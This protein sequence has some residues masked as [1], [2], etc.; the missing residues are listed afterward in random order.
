M[1]LVEFGIIFLKAKS[2]PNIDALPTQVVAISKP[3]KRKT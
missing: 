1:W 2:I 3:R